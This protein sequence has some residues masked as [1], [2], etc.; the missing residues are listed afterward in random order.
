MNTNTRLRPGLLWLL[1][2][3]SLPCSLSAQDTPPEPKADPAP[4]AD[5]P[6]VV[7]PGAALPGAAAAAPAMKDTDVILEVDG[8]PIRLID[9]REL[10]T[11]R[12]GNQFESMPPEQRAMIEPQLQQMVV[13]ELIQRTLLTNAAAKEEI[14]ADQAEIDTALAEIAKRI[15]EGET[16]E[17][18]SK[19][20]GVSLDRIRDQISTETK[21]RKLYEKVTADITAPGEAEVKKYF[22][23]HPDEF[24][25]QASVDAAHILIATKDITD[26][27]QLAAKEKIAKELREEIVSKKGENFADMAKLHSDCPSKVQGGDL[28]EFQRG[29]MVPEFEKAAFAQEIGVVGDLVKTDFGYHII[30]VN[31]RKDAKTLQ[32]DEVKEKLTETLLDQAKGKKME[33]YVADLQKNAKII[34]PGEAAAPGAPAAPAA[35]AAPKEAL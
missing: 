17:S 18:F 23:E 12:Y 20:A 33:A 22:E 2:L 27:T 13:N 4:A 24:E 30:K 34:R 11:G 1:G 15:P 31:D 3:L 6:A 21:L 25:Q 16:L 19:S 28:G 35:P 32:F 5:A 10:F 9:L 7:A 14:K 8:T 26:P 29:Q